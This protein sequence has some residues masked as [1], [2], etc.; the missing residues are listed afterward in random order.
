MRA[1]EATQV[2]ILI[3][4]AKSLRSLKMPKDL[5]TPKRPNGEKNSENCKNLRKPQLNHKR[6]EY[7][8]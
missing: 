5:K 1:I 6:E 7:I 4:S 3:A 2:G 8:F